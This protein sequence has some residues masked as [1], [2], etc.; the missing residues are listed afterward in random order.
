MS[1]WGRGAP[2]GGKQWHRPP[3]SRLTTGEEEGQGE[4]SGDGRSVWGVEG[5][6]SGGGCKGE[7]A[8][9]D[10][11]GRGGLTRLRGSEC[12]DPRLPRP[13]GLPT[14][15]MDLPGRPESRSPPW[16]WW[17]RSPPTAAAIPGGPSQICGSA[18]PILLCPVDL[19]V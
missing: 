10:V 17:R 2:S 14:R 4:G 19:F 18:A 1:V 3:L 11:P 15:S 9:E 16:G 7:N 8:W 12:P 6:Q 5:P 13:L